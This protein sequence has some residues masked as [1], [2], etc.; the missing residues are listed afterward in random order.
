MKEINGFEIEVYNQH[1]FVDGVKTSTCPLCSEE[2]KK[3]SDKCVKLDWDKGFANCFHCGES[4]QL[5][6]YKKSTELKNYIIPEFKYNKV[7]EKVIEW[8]KGRGISQMTLSRLKI[9]ESK[10]WMPQT[11]KEEN[12]INF[13]YFLDEKLVNIKYRDGR[14][15]FKLFKDAEKILYN[16]DSIR[17]AKEC[18]IVEGE[19][20]CLSF[21]ESEIY[22]VVSVPN[23]FNLQGN[24]NLDYLNNYL[25]YFDNKEKIYLALDNDEAGIKGK[26]EFIRRLGSERCYLVDFKDCKDANEYL[27]KYGSLKEVIEKAEITPLE[28]VV[29]LN[30]NS[31]ALDDFW[32]NGT[33]QGMTFD[34]PDFDAAYS[35]E[36]KQYTLLTGVP[37]SGKSEFLDQLLVK[38]NLNYGEKVGFCSLENEPFIYHYDKLFQKIYG[39][40]PKGKAEI[41]S[42]NVIKVKQHISDNFFHIQKKSRYWLQ[43]VLAKFEE[44][45]KRKGV[46]IF[47]IDP[48]N[49]VKLKDGSQDINRYTEEYHILIDDFCKRLDVHVFL[50][51]HPVKVSLQEG[52]AMTFV[53]PHAYNLKG[54]GEHFDMSYNIIGLNRI[55]EF[56]LVHVKTLKVKFRHIGTNQHDAYFSYNTVNGRYEELVEQPSG[57]ELYEIPAKNLDYKNWLSKENNDIFEERTTS[58]ADQKDNSFDFDEVPF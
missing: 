39:R 37:Q 20:D 50:V 54:G 33:E 48:Y 40:K 15:N 47:V 29:V 18:I 52:S 24:V 26:E 34:L 9:S 21:I 3:K 16:L 53:M 55:Y 45:R 44:L 32:L 46:R 7:S 42:E 28:E 30:D 12:T 14:K 51:L 35:V 58:L 17:T 5:H 36:M 23:G 38:L 43:E 8:F 49:K 27:I 56:K 2:R 4:L 25:N 41:L 57:G 31:D 22:N 13:N 11:K 6:T 10:E 19:I 1:G